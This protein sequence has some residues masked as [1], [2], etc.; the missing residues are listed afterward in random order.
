MKHHQRSWSFS[1]LVSQFNTLTD[2]RSSGGQISKL[3]HQFQGNH[4]DGREGPVPCGHGGA[5][6]EVHSVTRGESSA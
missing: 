2:F 1:R 3:H 4:D 5:D 6:A